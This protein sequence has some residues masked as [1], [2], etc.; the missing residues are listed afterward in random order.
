MEIVK[1]GRTELTITEAKNC[2]ENNLYVCN[3]SGIFQPF[4]SVASEQY[5]FQ[6]VI[7]YKGYAKRGRFY[8]QTAEQINHVLGKKILIGHF[9]MSGDCFFR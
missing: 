4:Y 8:I 2:Y 6:K 3:Y 1:A 5:Y 7:D 9:R